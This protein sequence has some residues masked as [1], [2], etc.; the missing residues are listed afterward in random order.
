[1]V[2]GELPVKLQFLIV[3]FVAPLPAAT[4]ASQT[5]L[6]VEVL[7]LVLINVRFFV[8]PPTVLEPSIVTQ[9]APFNFIIPAALLPVITGNF[10]RAGFI[11]NVFTALAYALLLITIGKVS[12]G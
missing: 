11:D 2:V 9:S 5:I 12:D 10:V 1:M 4:L 3:L 7:V 8:M 6:L